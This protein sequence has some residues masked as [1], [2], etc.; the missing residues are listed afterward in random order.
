VAHGL[1]EAWL[2]MHYACRQ[3]P[4]TTSDLPFIL[5]FYSAMH[6]SAKC[7]IAIACRPS[8]CPSV[9]LVDHD[10]IGWKYWKQ[11]ARTI[12]PTPSLFAA[13]GHPPTPRGTWGN[14]EVTRGGVS[15]VG[16]RLQRCI[17]QW[18]CLV[19]TFRIDNAS[20]CRQMCAVM[21]QFR[22]ISRLL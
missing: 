6:Y 14:F 18:I 21:T 10:H 7:G 8:I 12:S 1:T 9:T 13:K 20:F 11:I 17:F 16:V 5:S 2:I 4:H 19:S 15:T 3:S 22:I